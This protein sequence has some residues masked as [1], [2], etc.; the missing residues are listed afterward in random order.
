MYMNILTALAGLGLLIW[1]AERLLNA[2]LGIAARLRL[3]PVAIGATALALGTS[4][5]EVAVAI[6]AV[7]GQHSDI[8]VG[9]AIGSNIANIGLALGVTALLVPL[10]VNAATLRHVLPLSLLAVAVTCAVLVDMQLSRINGFAL[11]AG[12]ACATWLMLS[13]SEPPVDAD[14]HG[15]WSDWLWFAIGVAMLALGAKLL[16]ASSSQLALDFGVSELVVGVSAVA[17]GTSLPELST[18]LHAARRGQHSIAFGNILGSNV[19][20]LFGVLGLTAVMS[21]WQATD[22]TLLYRDISACLVLS[23]AI[24][25]LLWI[26]QWRGIAPLRLGRFTAILLLGFYAGYLAVLLTP[27]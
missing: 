4:L 16:V 18:S 10:S 19:F 27:H 6:S 22:N 17:I 2:S 8:A 26:Q 12:F 21:P 14:E 13:P 7:Y 5:P 25:T 23:M 11:L 15:G 9:N 3:P 1:S 20:N 24:A